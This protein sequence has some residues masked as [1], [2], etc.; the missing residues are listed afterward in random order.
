MNVFSHALTVRY[1]RT[2]LRRA[3][4]GEWNSRLVSAAY[5]HGFAV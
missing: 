1:G 4:A 3:A 2:L 5:D